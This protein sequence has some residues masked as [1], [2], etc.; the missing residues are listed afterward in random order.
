MAIT[1]KE[2][3]PEWRR[4]RS[5]Q[6]T[7][8]SCPLTPRPESPVDWRDTFFVPSHPHRR[9]LLPRPRESPYV[10]ATWLA[11]LLAG[12]NSCE[13]AGWFRSHYQDWARPPSD[14]DQ[15][16]WM[17]DHTAL[18][19]R[20]RESRERLGYTVFTEN[21]NSFRLRGRSATVAGKPDLIALKGSDAVIV[22][23]RTGKPG[24]A[25]AAQVLIYMYAVPKAL[26][27]YRGVEFRGHVVYPESQVGIPVSAVD[28]KFT[29]NL[30][31][32]IRRLASETPARRVPSAQ[33]CAFCDITKSDC[34]ERVEGIAPGEATT[35]DF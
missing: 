11:K 18:V 32:L 28:K 30:G 7:D 19:P 5:N 3:S 15:A 2:S 29:E 13:W 35:D 33:E 1:G 22:D 25:H 14:F 23:A 16:Q 8:D 21:Q 31:S 34:P 20:E 24:P 9:P 26:E 4:Q 6:E 10:W 12:E 17:L 27:Q